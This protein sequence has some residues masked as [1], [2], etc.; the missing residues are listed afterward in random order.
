[1]EMLVSYFLYLAGPYLWDVDNVRFTFLL[2]VMA[3][4]MMYVCVYI[5]IYMPACVWVIVYVYVCINMLDAL[6]GSSSS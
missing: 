3:L 1:M 5:Y 4:C 6:R 2:C